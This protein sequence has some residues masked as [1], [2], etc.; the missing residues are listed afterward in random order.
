MKDEHRH[1]T[2]LRTHGEGETEDDGLNWMNMKK[3]D[4]EQSL[5]ETSTS[6]SCK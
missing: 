1:E 6:S 5:S 2:L 3:G 4:N